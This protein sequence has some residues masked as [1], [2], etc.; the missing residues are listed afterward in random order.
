MVERDAN[1]V[2][3]PCT[4]Y[5]SEISIGREVQLL[6]GMYYC[7]ICDQLKTILIIII[8]KHVA[9]THH[10]C[11]AHRMLWVP[12]QEIRHIFVHTC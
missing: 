11:Y 12:L 5:L 8:P 9:E 4:V 6:L 7:R 2:S 3:K 1:S 10:A